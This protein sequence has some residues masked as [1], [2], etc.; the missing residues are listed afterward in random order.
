MKIG[1][2][3]ENFADSETREMMGALAEGNRLFISQ[4]SVLIEWDSGDVCYLLFRETS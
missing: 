1:K 3:R 2:G 4:T